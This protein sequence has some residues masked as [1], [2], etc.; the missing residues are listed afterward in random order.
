MSAPPNTGGVSSGGSPPAPPH[1]GHAP[2]DIPG[3]A[4]NFAAQIAAANQ[5]TAASQIAAM[6]QMMT[7]TQTRFVKPWHEA[8]VQKAATGAELAHRDFLA[9]HPHAVDGPI[10]PMDWYYWMQMGPYANPDL[11]TEPYYWGAAY[12][13][14]GGAISAPNPPWDPSTNSF[15]Q[16]NLFRPDMT[17]DLNVLTVED[18][19]ANQQIRNNFSFDEG[20]HVHEPLILSPQMMNP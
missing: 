11:F 1:G 3:S 6:H 2:A 9:S 4:E 20:G 10:D 5:A 17:E 18:Y 19:Y 16:T 15:P 7:S 12:N 14:S 13:S 8:T